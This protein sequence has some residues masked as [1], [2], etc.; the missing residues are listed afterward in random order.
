MVDDVN[1]GNFPL[2]EFFPN[3]S[4]QPNLFTGGIS[5]DLLSLLPFAISSEGFKGC[6]DE[7]YISGRPLDFAKNVDLQA[8]AFNVCTQRNGSENEEIHFFNGEAFAEYGK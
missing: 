4:L 6:L 3:G 2:G 7:V 1:T 5:R 8:V